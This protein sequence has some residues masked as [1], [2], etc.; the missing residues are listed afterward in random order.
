MPAATCVSRQAL[1]YHDITLEQHGPGGEECVV[2]DGESSEV[3]GGGGGGG[4]GQDGASQAGFDG[5]DF[6]HFLPVSA[7]YGSLM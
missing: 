6:S 3:R 1:L 4:G 2:C 7:I 5:T